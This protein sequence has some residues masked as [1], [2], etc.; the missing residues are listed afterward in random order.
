MRDALVL[1]HGLN[2]RVPAVGPQAGGVVEGKAE[3]IAEF[4]AGY[5]LGL[6]FVIARGPFAGK[7]DLSERW[8]AGEQQ[9]DA[10]CGSISSGHHGAASV[11]RHGLVTI[12]RRLPFVVSEPHFTFWRHE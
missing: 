12:H 1:G 5:A 10:D 8:K 11:C 6:I 2:R 3:I 7:V 9:K 4:G